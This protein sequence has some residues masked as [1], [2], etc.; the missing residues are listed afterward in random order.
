MAATRLGVVMV[1]RVRGLAV[2][3]SGFVIAFVGLVVALVG[4][5]FEMR[6]L[7]VGGFFVTVTGVFVGFAGILYGW[8]TEGPKALT[9]SS[10]AMRDLSIKMARLFDRHTNKRSGS[11]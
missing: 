3:F 1:Q 4:F 9:G 8:L 6:W 11:D 7:S 10:E 2:G 5:Q